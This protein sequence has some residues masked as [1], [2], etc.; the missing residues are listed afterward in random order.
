[1][2]IKSKTKENIHTAAI[3][4]STKIHDHNPNLS[5]ARVAPTS[6]FCASTMLLLIVGN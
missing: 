6:Q 1:M 5:G 4:R 3:L 2:Y